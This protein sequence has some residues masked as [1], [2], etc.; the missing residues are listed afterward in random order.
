MERGDQRMRRER[1][2]SIHALVEDDG[3]FTRHP[4][5][6]GETRRPLH[7][8]GEMRHAETEL[9]WKRPRWSRLVLRWVACGWP[10]AERSERFLMRNLHWGPQHGRGPCLWALKDL[11]LPHDVEWDFRHAILDVG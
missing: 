8:T 7:A 2:Q 6:G 9:L 5:G 1:G 4:T 11:P 10:M 3:H